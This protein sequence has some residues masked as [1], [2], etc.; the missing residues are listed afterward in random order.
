MSSDAPHLT[1][2]ADGGKFQV[3]DQDASIY[4]TYDSRAEADEA[5]IDWKNYYEA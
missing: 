4:G 2:Y 3:R 5:L 1:V